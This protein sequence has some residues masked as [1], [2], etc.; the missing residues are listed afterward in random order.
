MIILNTDPK[1]MFYVVAPDG[2]KEV[3]FK[4]PF[5]VKDKHRIELIDHWS[6]SQNML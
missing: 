3:A 2:T 1:P 6:Y 5:K 4:F